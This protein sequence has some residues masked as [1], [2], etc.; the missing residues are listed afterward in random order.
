MPLIGKVPSTGSTPSYMEMSKVPVDGWGL[1]QVGGT[2]QSENQTSGHEPEK[3]VYGMTEVM[4][5][6]VP[7]QL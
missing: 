7:T 6:Q 4:V 1:M 3:H 5:T 2:L